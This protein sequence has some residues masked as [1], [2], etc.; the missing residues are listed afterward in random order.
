MG[1][2]R[3]ELRS[4]GDASWTY[5]L[6]H[7]M[8]SWGWIRQLWLR[9]CCC[10][11]RLSIAVWSMTLLRTNADYILCFLAAASLPKGVPLMHTQRESS[12]RHRGGTR[13]QPAR[14]PDSIHQGRQSDA[15]CSKGPCSCCGHRPRQKRQHSNVAHEWIIPLGFHSTRWPSPRTRCFS[16][17]VDAEQAAPRGQGAFTQ[18]LQAM[19]SDHSCRRTDE[20]VQTPTSTTLRQQLLWSSPSYT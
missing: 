9:I 1:Q 5:R 12:L 8:S 20:A 17:L 19:A 16:S 10:H 6:S 11:K 3:F 15:L 2:Q 4:S 18:T 7:R 13:G 14:L